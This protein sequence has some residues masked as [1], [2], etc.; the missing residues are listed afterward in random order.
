M[1]WKADEGFHQQ[2]VPP[3][4]AAEAR[5]MQRVTSMSRIIGGLI[6][7][8]VLVA[9]MTP[10]LI[11][12]LP[13]RVGRIR[14]TNAF[15]T[16]IG[17]TVLWFSGCRVTVEGAEHI[18][19]GR[20]AIYACNHTSILDAFTTIWLTPAGTVGVA[21]KEVFY[22]PFYGQAWWLAGH[23]FLDRAQT[24]RAKA[25]LKKTAAFIKRHR[26][27]LCILPEGTRSRTG[28]L[29]PFKKGIVHLALETKLPIVPMVTIGL[30]EVWQKSTLQLR[31]ASVRIVFLPPIDTTGW[32]AGQMDQQ[33]ESLRAPFLA[34]LPPDQLPLPEAAR[35]SVA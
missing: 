2:Y 34:A 9:L 33:L 29:L 13:W 6:C 28:R 23:V 12:L 10:A 22:Y 26:L 7:T 4:A 19:A 32:T 5:T 17:R 14:V 11:I 31:P 15:G 8:G 21:K 1:T 30:G 35:A 24:D 27:H 3:Q 20:P 18:G 16:L 25:T